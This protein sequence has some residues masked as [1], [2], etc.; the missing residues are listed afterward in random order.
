MIVLFDDLTKR[1]AET[2]R[3]ICE[4]LGVDTSAVN[5]IDSGHASNGYARPR[6]RVSQQLLASQRLTNP[7]LKYMPRFLLRHVRNRWLLQSAKKPPI[8]HAARDMLVSE[9]R[10]EIDKLEK[11]LGRDLSPLRQSWS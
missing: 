6:G 11:L 10:S 5:Q 8:D 2:L 7:L 3:H 4:F 1:P 9:Y